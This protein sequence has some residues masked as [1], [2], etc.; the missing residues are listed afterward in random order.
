AGARGGRCRARPGSSAAWGWWRSFAFPFRRNTF[1]RIRSAVDGVFGPQG[2]FEQ[3][4]TGIPEI[5]GLLHPLRQL[6]ERLLLQR[7]EVVAALDAPAD[8]PGAL[9]QAD[10]L[11]D[12]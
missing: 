2:G 4:E 6:V 10:V 12:R 1:G 8:Q 11:G 3:V 7:E 9:E 5:A